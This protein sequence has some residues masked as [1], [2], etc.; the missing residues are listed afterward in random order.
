MSGGVA[1]GSSPSKER[2][3]GV[4]GMSAS[5]SLTLISGSRAIEMLYTKTVLRI[6]R[7][8]VVKSRTLSLLIML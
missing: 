2:C 6:R 1:F 8:G 4:R 5:S 3:V 7:V